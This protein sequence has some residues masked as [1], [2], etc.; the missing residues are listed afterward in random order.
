[1]S[2]DVVAFYDAVAHD[3]RNPLNTLSMTLALLKRSDTGELTARAGRAMDRLQR[4]HDQ[5]VGLSRLR[6]EGLVVRKHVLTLDE[7]CRRALTE[8]GATGLAIES[9]G[10]VTV[11]GDA[12]LLVRA[13]SELVRNVVEHGG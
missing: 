1:M 12:D 10:N 2:T 6:G 4:M 3:L 11:A 13:V 9:P 5:L 7:V 8:V